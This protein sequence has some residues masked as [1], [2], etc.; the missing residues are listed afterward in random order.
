MG[1]RDLRIA[2]IGNTSGVGSAIAAVQKANG[3]EVDVYVFDDVTERW[4][5]GRRINY[6]SFLSKKLFYRKLME[7]DVWHYHYPYGSLKTDLEQRKSNKIFLKHYHGDDLRNR[8]DTEFCVVSTPDLLRFA[9]SGRWIPNPIDL[10]EIG[11][12]EAIPS[13]GALR[14]AHYM[15][16]GPIGS[17]G[18]YHSA[19]L[20]SLEKKGLCLVSRITGR[21]RRETLELIAGC[22]IVVGK[23]LP[24]IGWF[25]KFELEGMALGKPVIAYVSDELYEK[26][27]PPIF[28][29]TKDTFYQDL[30]AL[31][32]DDERRSQLSREGKEYVM[33]QHDVR[34]V[35]RLIDDCYKRV[36]AT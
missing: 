14:I 24:E 25:G 26:Y 2:H 8:H 5:G 11:S 22:D 1:T 3:H 16:Y 32:T 12:I 9:P 29:T 20:Q 10:D 19:A 7:Y 30:L 21:S 31:L 18:D 23:I 6:N 33:K 4:F 36:A 34:N 27:N 28:R 13:K 15:Y 35:T 17:P